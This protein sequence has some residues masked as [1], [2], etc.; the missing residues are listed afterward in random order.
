M[1]SK[2]L[3]PSAQ[4]LVGGSDV[5]ALALAHK[6]GGTGPQ[7]SNERDRQEGLGSLAGDQCLWAHFSAVP[8]WQ[9]RPLYQPTQRDSFPAAG[10]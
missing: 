8:G 6:W 3:L 2:Y 4:G 1:S 9:V 10:Q 7:V 5:C